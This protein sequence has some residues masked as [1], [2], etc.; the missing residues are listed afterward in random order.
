MSR[1]RL[2]AFSDGVFAIIITIMTGGLRRPSCSEDLRLRFE[3]FRSQRES[4][5]YCSRFAKYPGR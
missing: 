2:E 4:A 3:I 1:G 5:R